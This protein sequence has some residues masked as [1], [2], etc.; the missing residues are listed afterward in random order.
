MEGDN[1]AY[2]AINQSGEDKLTQWVYLLRQFEELGKD[3]AKEV[4]QPHLTTKT[5]IKE[6]I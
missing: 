6:K 4:E 1:N 5:R 2:L 3:A